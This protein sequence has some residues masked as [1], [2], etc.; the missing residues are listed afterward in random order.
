MVPCSEY[1][2]IYLVHKYKAWRDMLL[3]ISAC[4]L[5]GSLCIIYNITQHIACKVI[6]RNPKQRSYILC[7]S[8]I[9]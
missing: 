8:N 2:K 1:K 3:I 5:S 7:T 4:Q 6:P 9:M